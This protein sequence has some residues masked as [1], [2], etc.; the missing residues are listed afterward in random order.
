[1][2]IVGLVIIAAMGAGLI[3]QDRKIQKL[4]AQ[5]RIDRAKYKEVQLTKGDHDRASMAEIAQLRKALRRE[6]SA[7]SRER[8]LKN[9]FKR[10]CEALKSTLDDRD[11]EIESL[12]LAL[13]S[14]NGTIRAMMGTEAEE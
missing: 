3:V 4:K 7:A 14:A 13:D 11:D 2:H 9:G 1:M 12:R 8:I 6:Q 10:N 5:R